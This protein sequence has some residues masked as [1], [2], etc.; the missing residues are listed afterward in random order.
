MKEKLK[1]NEDDKNFLYKEEVCYEHN[2]RMSL[3]NKQKF[4][5]WA[6]DEAKQLGFD[7]VE[8]KCL[9]ANNV[10]IGNPEK[11]EIIVC[12]HYDT[13]PAMNKHIIKHQILTI[14]LAYPVALILSL[15][16]LISLSANF[17]PVGALSPTLDAIRT[18][19]QV[20]NFGIFAYMLG[21]LG[22]ANEY[23]HDDNSSGVISVMQLMDKYKDL[24]EDKKNKVA[25]VLFD[26]E[27]K[28]LWG[29]LYYAH[30]HKKALKNQTV[31]NLDCVGVAKTMNLLYTKNK[32]PTIAEDFEKEIK[33]SCKDI[34]PNIKKT[35]FF[36]MSDHISFSKAKE[37]ICLLAKDKSLYS[38]VNHIHSKND[39]FIN[40]E[41]ITQV[42]EATKNII[43]KKLNNINISREM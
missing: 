21:F 13:P 33:E 7:A 23:N 39:T 40:N 25:F 16:G 3:K 32:I 14:G 35:T 8:E 31:I 42:V 30:K 27:E 22:N 19:A 43:D 20:L 41:N 2:S 17:V 29:S 34:V 36:S 10:V 1:I 26:N 9:F 38:L 12:A 37:S 6:V 24:P 5:T 4:R 18:G 15:K 11:A 28:M